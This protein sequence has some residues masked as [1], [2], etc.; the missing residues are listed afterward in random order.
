VTSR[1][2]RVPL[3]EIA[4]VRAI[5]EGYDGIALLRAPDANRG[6]I[7]LVIGEGLDDEAETV[8]RRLREEAGL[9]E[10]ARP[11]DWEVDA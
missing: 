9:I 3:A 2:Y 1:F 6:E 8:A 11:D 7:E 5:V 4:Y 10:I